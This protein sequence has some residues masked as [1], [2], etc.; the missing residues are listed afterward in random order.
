MRKFTLTL[1]FQPQRPKVVEAETYVVNGGLLQFLVGTQ[2]VMA[3]AAANVRK[4]AEAKVEVPE[5][6]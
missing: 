3:T 4:M 1:S 2:V 5:P 6:A